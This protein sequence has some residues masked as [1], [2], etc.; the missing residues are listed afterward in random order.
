MPTNGIFTLNWA[1]FAEAFVTAAIF[2]IF[3]AFAA[4]VQQPG[5]SLFT[6]DWLTT[7]K[8]MID[9]GFSAGFVIIVKEL[10]S[11]NAG[12]VLNLTPTGTSTTSGGN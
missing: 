3:T 5:F 9:I 10:L 11:T 6:L 7:I 12:S 8:N 1:S 4:I 2:A